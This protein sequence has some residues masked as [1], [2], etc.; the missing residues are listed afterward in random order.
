MGMKV[1]DHGEG[2]EVSVAPWWFVV[3]L[4]LIL[5]AFMS[6]GFQVNVGWTFIVTL[7]VVGLIV[8][9]SDQPR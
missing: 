9:T 3:V 1:K 5:W 8:H 7:I 2:K 4:A 6:Q